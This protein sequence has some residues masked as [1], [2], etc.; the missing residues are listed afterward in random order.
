MAQLAPQ[1]VQ[2]EPNCMV[3]CL[4][5]PGAALADCWQHEWQ[6]ILSFDRRRARN[7]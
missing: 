4:A 7:L 2:Q 1:L 3:R 6:P 5:H